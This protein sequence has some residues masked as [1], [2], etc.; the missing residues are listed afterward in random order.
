MSEVAH[1]FAYDLSTNI[2]AC[3]SLIGLGANALFALFTTRDLQNPGA[4][5]IART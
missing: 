4:V 5:R 2:L 3:G 1:I